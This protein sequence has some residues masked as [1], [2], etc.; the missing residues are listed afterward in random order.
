[1]DAHANSSYKAGFYRVQWLS[2]MVSFKQRGVE[3]VD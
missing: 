2:M 1:V 3:F